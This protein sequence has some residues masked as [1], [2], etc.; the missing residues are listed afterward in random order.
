M[1]LI[2]FLVFY[3]FSQFRSFMIGIIRKVL[4]I[5]LMSKTANLASK[6]DDDTF[7]WLWQIYFSNQLVSW[8]EPLRRA[9][10]VA[11]SSS[12][13]RRVANS[14]LASFL[15]RCRRY[16]LCPCLPVTPPRRRRRYPPRRRRCMI[17]F[18]A[19][20]SDK[21]VCICTSRLSVDFHRRFVANVSLGYWYRIDI[22]T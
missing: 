21:D 20:T 2:C 3:L 8:L 4:S 6:A 22:A 16:R 19:A 11:S 10:R 15:H 18:E 12:R 13:R 9:R 14:L 5:V 1:L 17:I 7:A